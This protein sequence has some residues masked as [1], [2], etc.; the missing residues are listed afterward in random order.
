MGRIPI[1]PVMQLTMEYGNLPF[2]SSGTSVLIY[3]VSSMSIL[4]DIFLTPENAGA[5]E[6]QIEAGALS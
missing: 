4:S 2:V 6:S 3:S 1:F 5:F